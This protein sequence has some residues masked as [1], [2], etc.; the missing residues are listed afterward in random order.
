MSD[1]F[2]YPDDADGSDREPTARIRRWVAVG[3]CAALVL[4]VLIAALHLTGVV[5][6]K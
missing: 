5:G 1:P 2:R 6:P 3:I 4:L